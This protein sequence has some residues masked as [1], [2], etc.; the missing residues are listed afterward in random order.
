MTDG[1]LLK[2][3][4]KQPLWELHQGGTLVI[5]HLALGAL[6]KACELVL[7]AHGQGNKEVCS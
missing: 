1:M 4:L 5:F 3:Q 7:S 6:G 2:E